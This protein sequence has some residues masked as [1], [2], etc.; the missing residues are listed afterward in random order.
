MSSESFVVFALL[1]HTIAILLVNVLGAIN[2]LSTHSPLFL[3]SLNAI[4]FL[5]SCNLLLELA[6]NLLLS[7]AINPGKAV[8]SA[9][10]IDGASTNAHPEPDEVTCHRAPVG[11][12]VTIVGLNHPICEL[13]A[14]SH[15]QN[16]NLCLEVLATLPEP[17]FIDFAADPFHPAKTPILDQ[18]R[19]TAAGEHDPSLHIVVAVRLA[20]FPHQASKRP[21]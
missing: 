7:G 21:V 11:A 20:R 19:W 15:L 18:G 14:F 16:L 6:L 3:L 12:L 8:D 5:P 9:R 4:I 2:P 1:R 10:D 17:T 13:A